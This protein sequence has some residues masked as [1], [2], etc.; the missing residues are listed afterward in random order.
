MSQHFGFPGIYRINPRPGRRYENR[1]Q[2]QALAGREVHVRR[3]FTLTNEEGG[4][5]GGED[6]YITTD[7]DDLSLPVWI[8]SGDLEAVDLRPYTLQPESQA[9]DG[10]P[11]QT[12]LS[13]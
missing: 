3:G 13:L 7:Q 5:Y 4:I 10:R 2:L 6:A 11:A 9:G 12:P 8:P 1:P